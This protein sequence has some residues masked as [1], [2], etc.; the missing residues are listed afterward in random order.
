MDLSSFVEG[1]QVSTAPSVMLRRPHYKQDQ[2][3]F[4]GSL[5]PSPSTYSLPVDLTRVG[6]DSV[7][8]ELD[9]YVAKQSQMRLGT[10]MEKAKEW[11]C[12]HAAAHQLP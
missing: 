4:S 6:R 7:K 1:Q 11:T 5:M 3:S 2:G 8:K 12:S 10:W 9:E